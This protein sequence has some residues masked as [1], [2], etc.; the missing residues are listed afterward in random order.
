[1]ETAT[2]RIEIDCLG[3]D[4]YRYR[5][6]KVDAP[7]DAKPDLTL[8]HGECDKVHIGL[9]S[10]HFKNGD[11]DYYVSHDA[12]PYDGYVCGLIVYKNGKEILSEDKFYEDSD[13]NN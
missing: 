11:Y 5:S 3:E 9:Y 7:Q 13:V 8:E 2:Y 1:M 12:A 6:W 10:W 4:N